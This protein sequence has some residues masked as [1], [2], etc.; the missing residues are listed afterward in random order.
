MIL[1]PSLPLES[2]HE[3]LLPY[4]QR[5]KDIRIILFFKLKSEVLPREIFDHISHLI[6]RENFQEPVFH[7]ETLL[8]QLHPAKGRITCS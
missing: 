5:L 3:P 7:D 1:W 4:L 8:A 6:E 2:A